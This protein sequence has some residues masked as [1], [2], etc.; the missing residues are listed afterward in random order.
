MIIIIIITLVGIAI[1]SLAEAA[2]YGMP[3]HKIKERSGLGEKNCKIL[4]KLREQIIISITGLL[5]THTVLSIIGGMAIAQ[6]Q[7]KQIA[8][9]HLI[10]GYSLIQLVFCEI[11]PK[12]YGISHA[13]QVAP[14]LSPMIQWMAFFFYPFGMICQ[15]VGYIFHINS[16]KS[17]K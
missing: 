8:F 2:F 14:T 3:I 7:F 15:W 11:T 6:L 5:I 9:G 10:A 4:L 16:K 13:E 17:Q 12:A 1:T